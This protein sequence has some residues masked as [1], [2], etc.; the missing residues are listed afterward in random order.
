M[1][2]IE[3]AGL[4][5]EEKV[6]R[7]NRV[8]K[9]V[10]GGRRF[11]FSAMVVVGDGQ[12]VVGVGLGKANE[13][14]D[15]I[16]K[17]V[18]TAKKNLVRVPLDGT[19]L[20]HQ[21]LAKFGAARVLLK[22]AAPGTGLI[23]G[24]AVRVVLNAAGVKDALSKSLGSANPI[25]VARAT[26]AGLALMRDPQEAKRERRGLAPAHAAP[27]AAPPDYVA[28][29]ATDLAA[30]RPEAITLE[31]IAT[32]APAPAAIDLAAIAPE[33]AVPEAQAAPQATSLAAATAEAPPPEAPVPAVAKPEEAP[34][35]GR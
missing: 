23:A 26:I 31:V 1:P 33:A 28:P 3:A 20:P 2:K 19:T 24:G 9:V 7:V 13:V 10:K 6:I 18:E 11:H 22:P 27:D 5:L 17:G 8:A 16:R 12:G 32:E 15:S 30:I 34:S 25:N 21:A 35:D 29:A 14:P 4:V